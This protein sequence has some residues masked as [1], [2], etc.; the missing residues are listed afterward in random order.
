VNDS[1]VRAGKE[2]ARGILRARDEDEQ[3]D[4]R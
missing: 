2:L 1:V 4:D 3:A